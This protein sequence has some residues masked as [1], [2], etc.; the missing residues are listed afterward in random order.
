LVGRYL[1]G[2]RRRYLVGV[3]RRY[4]LRLVVTYRGFVVPFVTDR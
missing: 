4:V 2:V 1:V 3:R